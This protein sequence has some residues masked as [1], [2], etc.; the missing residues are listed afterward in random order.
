MEAASWND[1]FDG[2]EDDMSFLTQEDSL[3]DL[4]RQ[5]PAGC[6]YCR[7]SELDEDE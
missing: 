7:L 3:N 6:L 5:A 1:L 2:Y 4:L